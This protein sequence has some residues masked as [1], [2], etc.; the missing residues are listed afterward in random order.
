MA[1]SVRPTAGNPRVK[2]ALARSSTARPPPP[3]AGTDKSN[4]AK[5]EAPP[6]NE[7]PEGAGIGLEE[8][9]KEEEIPPAEE[10]NAPPGGAEEVMETPPEVPS[11]PRASRLTQWQVAKLADPDVAAL[12][13]QLE[14][15][16]VQSTAPA[17]PRF[18]E[19][20]K[21]FKLLKETDSQSFF[22]I[23]NQWR[24]CEK[25][26]RS[27]GVPSWDR[28]RR[29]GFR[30]EELLWTGALDLHGAKPSNLDNEIH[31]LLSHDNFDDCPQHIYE[32]LMP[33]CRLATM[34]LTKDVCMQYW[35]TLAYGNR[36]LDI[37]RTFDAGVRQE[38]IREDV[39]LSAANIAEVRQYLK[40]LQKQENPIH[41]TFSAA[42]PL[43]TAYAASLAVCDYRFKHRLHP[44][45]KFRHTLIYLHQ[46]YYTTAERLSQLQYPDEAQKLR[47]NFLLA[48]SLLHELAHSVSMG[49]V[50]DRTQGREVF[51]YDCR[52]NELGEAWEASTWGGR[53]LPVNSRLDGSHGVAVCAWPFKNVFLDPEH[54]HN[55]WYSVPMGYIENIQQKKTWDKKYDLDDKPLLIPKTGAQSVEIVAFTTMK[56]SEEERIRRKE[57]EEA[58]NEDNEQPRMKKARI[59]IGE[60]RKTEGGRDDI[61]GPTTPPPSPPNPRPLARARRPRR[62]GRQG[63]GRG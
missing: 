17:S 31:P 58:V 25:R 1:V 6:K 18:V 2:R 16:G 14:R 52:I 10:G 15:I 8:H 36:E 56:W 19:T 54:E 47:F 39:P 13:D 48:N 43:Q 40:D 49:H 60:V 4:V 22:G 33:A 44:P 50:N 37:G 46:D 59:D 27:L 62:N 61:F 38:R 26:K 7:P 28:N 3:T 55:I 29:Y 57:M 35:V 23:R 53:I 12:A 24:Q 20:P 41:F 34:F 21:G 9:S 32:Q 5:D 63:Q 51:L 42:L 30:P 11:Q 45:N